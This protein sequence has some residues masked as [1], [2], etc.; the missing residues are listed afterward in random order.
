M[1]VNLISLTV[2][3]TPIDELEAVKNEDSTFELPLNFSVKYPPF[4]QES[5]I[6]HPNNHIKMHNEGY[7]ERNKVYRNKGSTNVESSIHDNF[8]EVRRKEL[9]ENA[10]HSPIRVDSR[11]TKEIIE[12]NLR[13]KTFNQYP[14]E[15]DANRY[16]KPFSHWSSDR[17]LNLVLEDAYQATNTNRGRAEVSFNQE[18]II[19]TI[20]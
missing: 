7:Y 1:A 19:G 3:E 20:F 18:I 8:I 15:K 5:F 14:M 9:A 4:L 17:N 10:S 16:P 6:D 13:A 12:Q 2:G 11:M